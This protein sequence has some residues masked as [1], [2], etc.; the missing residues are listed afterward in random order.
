MKTAKLIPILLFTLALTF[1]GCKKSDSKPQNVMTYT[2]NGNKY[3][4]SDP[5]VTMS[6]GTLQIYGRKGELTENIML[7]NYQEGS[8]NVPTIG[9][10]LVDV[11]NTETGIY[12]CNQGT[13]V[14]NSLSQTHIS[15]TFSGTVFSE[16]NSSPIPITGTF[17]VDLPK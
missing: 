12:S 14:V 17:D 5:E 9:A 16:I 4:L 2:L 3:S 6:T 8:H 11:D 7:S 15:G 13:I 1:Y 10:I